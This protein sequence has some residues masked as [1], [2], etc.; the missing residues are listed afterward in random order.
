MRILIVEDDVISRRVLEAFLRR[1]GY[2]V[3]SVAGGREALE[4]LNG[5]G[6]PSMVISDWVMPEMDGIDLCVEIRKIPSSRYIYF[7]LLT[8]KTEKSDIIKGLEAGA[9]DYMTKPFDHEELRCRIRIGERVLALERRILELANTDPLTGVL[10][11]RAL[12]ER[13]QV[14][15]ERSNREGAPLSLILADIDNFKRINDQYGHLVGDMA[16]RKFSEQLLAVIRPYDF[17]GRYGGEEFLVCFPGTEYP[18][19]MGVA[20]RMRRLVAALCF[21]TPDSGEC[22]SMTASFGVA[23]LKVRCEKSPEPLIR[24]A[25]LG[26]Y[27]AKHEGR[28]RVCL[29]AEG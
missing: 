3:I 23:A 22:Y 1:L 14:E 11:R 5:P 6:K 28:N 17:M 13:I 19:V 18:K 7:I 9:D 10:N 2:E 27:Q 16:L 20:E 8:S 21:S 15:I 4:A 29:M 26:M 24:R 12:M 25:D